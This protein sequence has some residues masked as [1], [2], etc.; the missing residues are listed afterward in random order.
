VLYATETGKS[1][2]YAKKLGEIFGHAFNSQVG[3]ASE[4]KIFLH[5]LGLI[6][7][8]TSNLKKGGSTCLRNLSASTRRKHPSAEST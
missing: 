7:L 4:T 2:M 6:S 1:E 5:L 3:L 8:L